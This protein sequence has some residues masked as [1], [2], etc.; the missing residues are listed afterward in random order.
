[1]IREDL[2]SSRKCGGDFLLPRGGRIKRMGEEDG[3]ATANQ[4]RNNEIH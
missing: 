4:K 2:A 3:R 1:V